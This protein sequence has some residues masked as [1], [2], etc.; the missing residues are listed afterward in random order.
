VLR[1]SI[2]PRSPWRKACTHERFED[3]VAAV[4]GGATGIGQGV[5][6][7]IRRKGAQVAVLTS[8]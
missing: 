2:V 5:L 7:E 3:K 1:G 4:T 8:L 6:P